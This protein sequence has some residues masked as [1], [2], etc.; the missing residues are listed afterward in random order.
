MECLGISVIEEELKKRIEEDGDDEYEDED[1]AKVT[2]WLCD[3]LFDCCF[4]F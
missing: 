3:C 1:L 2:K 4:I